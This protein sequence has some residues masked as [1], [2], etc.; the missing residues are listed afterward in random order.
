MRQALV[1]DESLIE[2]FKRLVEAALA[3]QHVQALDLTGYYLVHLLAAF[4]RIDAPTAGSADEPLALRLGRALETGGSRQRTQ[5]RQVGDQSLFVA[6]FFADSLRRSLVDVDY[7]AS[8]GGY[9]YGS[10]SQQ[11]AD[12]LAPVFA[13][14]AERFGA[15][16]DVLS[17]V[18]EASKLTSDSDLLRLYERWAR[19][20]SRRCGDLLA[21][22]GIVPNVQATRFHTH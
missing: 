10:L 5:L 7:Y 21:S 8:L 18:S 4:T 14:L 13:E 17:E 9:A 11:E 1:R 6:G 2:Y 16:A 3:H 15:F 12:V 20:G 19:G 22:R